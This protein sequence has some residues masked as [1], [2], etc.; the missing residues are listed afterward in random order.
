MS[1]NLI[2]IF[3]IWLPINIYNLL[4]NPR[5]IGYPIFGAEWCRVEVSHECW[6][7]LQ[8]VPLLAVDL[9]WESTHVGIAIVNHPPNHHKWVV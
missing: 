2:G 3:I 8:K 1:L 4:I 5:F 7:Q 6:L 9:S